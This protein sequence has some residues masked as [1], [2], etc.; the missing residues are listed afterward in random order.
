MARH[1]I[2][3]HLDVQD[4]ILGRLTTR[5]ALFLIVGAAA[6]YALG[7]ERSL[8]LDVRVPLGAIAAI[9]SAALALVRVGGRPLDDWLGSLVAY[10][11]TPRRATWRPR[12]PIRDATTPHESGGWRHRA[13]APRWSG[14]RRDG[15]ATTTPDYAARRA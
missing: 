8:S 10:L 6:A 1:E 14:V 12:S 2:P 7:T 3:T 15:I 4:R 11:F 9:A 5:D 13:T